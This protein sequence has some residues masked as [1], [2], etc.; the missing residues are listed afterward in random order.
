MK[1]DEVDSSEVGMA[2]L[3]SVTVAYNQCHFGGFLSKLGYECLL[4]FIILGVIVYYCLHNYSLLFLR[5]IRVFN[6]YYVYCVISI[7]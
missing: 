7:V 5:F 6:G 4:Q 1:N 3:L 2:A